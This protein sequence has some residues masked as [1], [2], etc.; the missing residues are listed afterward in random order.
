MKRKKR[1]PIDPI[2]GISQYIN[3]IIEDAFLCVYRTIRQTHNLDK[4]HL[5]DVGCGDG[6]LTR[7]FLN[8]GQHPDRIAGCDI[9]ERSIQ[10]CRKLN[11]AIH[12]F[13]HDARMP[14]PP[15]RNFDLI[16][17]TTVMA[18]FD[19]EIQKQVLENVQSRL[20]PCGYLLIVDVDTRD[21]R[22]LFAHLKTWARH[23]VLID[24]RFS[25]CFFGKFSA[26]MLADRIPF[27]ILKVLEKIVPGN[28][29]IRL[30]LL[31]SRT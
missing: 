18:Q 9:D 4:I 30:F 13:V 31:K 20:N 8:I 25:K 1:D 7:D 14:L 11:P 27:A 16:L 19:P 3:H 29:Q 23:K 22:P 6:G 10:F 17:F 5:L 15:D 21:T 24:R 2:G 28:F 26:V 12:Y